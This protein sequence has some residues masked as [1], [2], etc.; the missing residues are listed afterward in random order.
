MIMI[1]SG[2]I[3]LFLALLLMITIDCFYQIVGVELNLVL[4]QKFWSV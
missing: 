1:I 3:V 2:A 4:I